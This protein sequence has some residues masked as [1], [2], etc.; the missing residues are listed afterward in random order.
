MSNEIAGLVVSVD[1]TSAKQAVD[2]LD[3]LANA[4]KRTEQST[5]K[6]TD[7]FTALATKLFPATKTLAQLEQY[8]GML[9][10]KLKAGKI[11][12]QQYA[13][14]SEMVTR[15]Q[16]ALKSALY[17][18]HQEADRGARSWSLLTKSIMGLS[19]VGAVGL[20]LRTIIRE[21]SEAADVQAQLE[22]RIRST[23][24]AAGQTLDSLGKM[25]DE[26]QRVTTIDDESIGK[27]Q[28][29][30]L[31]FKNIGGT[32]FQP[33]VES[34]LNLSKAMSI[35]LNSAAK[36][37]G[38]AL[39]DPVKGMTALSR[40]GVQF[41]DAQEKLVAKLIETGDTAGAQR[42]V[43]AEL[44]EQ[45][46]GS[47]RAARDTLGGAVTSLKNNF[48]NLLEG[49]TNGNGV[50]GA[51]KA[52]NGLTDTLGSPET[53]RAFSSMI[54]WVFNLANAFA[55]LVVESTSAWD[56]MQRWVGFKI[57]DVAGF[58]Y[59][60]GTDQ[61]QMKYD[62]D[63]LRTRASGVMKQ[64]DDSRS[65]GLKPSP[66][67]V[68][69]AVTLYQE[70]AEIEKAR[71]ASIELFGTKRAAP[72]TPQ[73][74]RPALIDPPD[75]KDY[76]LGGD[77]GQKAAERM[78]KA[79]ETARK[80][81]QEEYKILIAGMMGE[82]EALRASYEKR[83]GIIE[84]ATAAGSSAR[85]DAMAMLDRVY[86]E[87]EQALSKKLNRD[88][89]QVRQSL[90][91][92]EQL[93]MQS[94]EKRKQIV[95][96]SRASDDE[97][98]A[99]ISQ[100]NAERD[101][102]KQDRIIRAEEARFDLMSRYMTEQEFRT[103]ADKREL[104]DLKRKLDQKLILEEDFAKAKAAIEERQR[105]HAI[106][107]QTDQMSRMS[108]L[109][110]SLGAL[111]TQ[112]SKGQGKAAERMFKISQALNLASAIMGIAAGI[113]EAQKLPYPQNWVEGIRVAALGAVQ[114][115]TIKGQ[116]FSGAYDKGGF[117]RAGSVGAVAEIGNELVNGVLVRGPARV[118]SREQTARM[119]KG[120][121]GDGANVKVEII[122]NSSAPA[123]VEQSS[124][125]TQ[126]LIK[127]II[128]EVAKDLGSNG[129]LAKAGE[130]VYGWRRQGVS[131][132]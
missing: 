61:E 34:V 87:E 52:I 70:I 44:E 64:I 107:M 21:T 88:L 58:K 108:D 115:A 56:R 76:D 78:A 66:Q 2:D 20:T 28:S 118:T 51:V 25:A 89:D 50:R 119:M 38:K 24:G 81:Q 101:L 18:T 98:A 30:L 40:A 48:A 104:D 124:D 3:R 128:G 82:E 127:V 131:R 16:A 42:V 85:V 32:T 12:A 79:V 83:K 11:D 111:A 6:V 41:T 9:N 47:A 74:N 36:M 110:S 95:L 62:A 39:N 43:L 121:S 77:D 29:V 7:E 123:Q 35:D 15:K 116:K 14:A 5:K 37:V 59:G 105:Q 80:R 13:H 22:A 125:G 8:Q 92:E 90:L 19:V 102:Y 53:Q 114:I 31:T 17:G 75:P 86:A 113:S 54:A 73:S 67:L 120:D 45:M 10:A 129:Q 97:K 130:Q 100:L 109:F 112:Y 122:N 68:R 23:G 93:F 106:S 46:G 94:I 99:L 4:G 71:K 49:D 126:R 65:R 1:S 63:K 26:L 132:G 103:E 96:E 57:G 27:I 91:S 33:A 84:A 60:T 117:I 69:Q 72:R 55:G